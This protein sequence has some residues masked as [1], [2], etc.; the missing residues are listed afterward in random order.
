[1]LVSLLRQWCSPSIGRITLSH[2]KQVHLSNKQQLQF[3]RAYSSTQLLAPKM[4]RRSSARVG[5]KSTEREKKAK[6]DETLLDASKAVSSLCD[7]IKEELLA[8]SSPKR[9]KV[10]TSFFK[11]GKGE[12]G[13]G[14]VFIGV[15]VPDQRTVVKKFFKEMEVTQ[16][17]PLLESPVHE[18][19]L[20]GLLILVEKY[21]KTKDAK[22]RKEIF[23]FFISNRKAINNWDLVDTTCP[24]SKRTLFSTCIFL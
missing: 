21:S 15:A 6:V 7:Q 1:M 18:H 10:S 17:S 13:E 3:F 2:L 24:K 8:L 11:T 12:Y 14:D 16:V 23:D 5:E 22:E 9:A 19:R 20:T 4:K